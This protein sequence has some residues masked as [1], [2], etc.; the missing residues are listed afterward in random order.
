MLVSG[1]AMNGLENALPGLC[2]SCW[3]ALP[4][5]ALGAIRLFRRFP[6]THATLFLIGVLASVMAVVSPYGHRSTSAIALVTIPFFL[7]VIFCVAG[8][9]LLCVKTYSE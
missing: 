7:L 1:V 6:L 2:L 9:V 3:V 4:L 8:L 5:V